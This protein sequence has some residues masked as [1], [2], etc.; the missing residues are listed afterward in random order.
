V[1]IGNHTFRATG[2]TA[3]LGNGATLEHAQSM[4]AHESPRTTRRMKWRG[5]GCENIDEFEPFYSLEGKFHD[6]RRRRHGD[7]EDAADIGRHLPAVVAPIDI[8]QRD[9]D[10]IGIKRS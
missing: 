2:I 5:S 1:P 3:S 6:Q 10:E 8:E 9:H 7:V 4:A